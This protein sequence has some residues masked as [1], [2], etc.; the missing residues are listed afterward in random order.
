MERIGKKQNYQINKVVVR[1]EQ[2]EKARREMK[3]RWEILFC[4]IK[5]QFDFETNA[6]GSFPISFHILR[7]FGCEECVNIFYVSF[8]THASIYL[9]SAQ[10]R[11]A[12][13][14]IFHCN[15]VN[16]ILMKV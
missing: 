16:V 2:D 7:R 1:T 15:G 13:A 14:N 9:H 6:F 4:L 8:Y 3:I 11:I 5:M 12:R 10:T